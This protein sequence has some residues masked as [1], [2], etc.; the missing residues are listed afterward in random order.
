MQ[1]KV[2][3]ATDKV[4][5]F[6]MQIVQI[7]HDCADEYRRPGL[8]S[9]FGVVSRQTIDSLKM[10]PVWVT[11]EHLVS[12][13][14]IVL[15]GHQLSRLPVVGLGGMVGFLTPEAIALVDA[16]AQERLRRSSG[17]SQWF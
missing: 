4:A 15:Q 12:T 1:L 13:A 5:V 17:L 16:E 10:L 6:Y 9:V 14:R 2:C 3:F 8:D 11:P 7:P